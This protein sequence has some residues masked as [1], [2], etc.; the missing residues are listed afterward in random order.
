M[1]NS[2]RVFITASSVLAGGIASPESLFRALC[3]ERRPATPLPDNSELGCLAGMEKQDVAILARHQLLALAAVE[4]AW[5]SAGLSTSR[6]RLRGEGGKIRHPTFACVSGS[7]LGGLCAMESDV[8]QFGA[9]KFPPYAV[10]RWRGNSVA[11]A[12]TLRYGLGGPDFS[13]NAASASGAQ[14]LFLAGSIVASGMA[15][16]VVAVAADSEL[17]PLLRAAMG[18]NGSVSH[19]SEHGPLSA[20]RSGMTP[21][22]GAACLILESEEH[23]TRR[24]T[25]PLAEWIG[26]QSANEA[27]HMMAPDPEARVLEG[28]IGRMQKL[29]HQSRGAGSRV[30]WVSLHATGTPRFDAAE[31]SCLQRVWG[32]NLPLISAM[33]R[34]TGH[35]LAASGLLEAALI[36]EGLR[37]GVLPPW[38]KNLDPALGLPISSPLTT[39]KPEIALQIGQGMGGTVVVNLLGHV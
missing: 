10:S 21:A 3:E 38:P 23:A 37:L 34:T 1:P 19:N 16:L 2:P 6:N 13:I 28:L 11:A 5:S 24:G 27:C 39:Q 17:T 35:A 15:D 31:I 18:R 20:G 14:I 12:A 22:E 25:K 26:G 36:C 33:K 7:S 30:D 9:K 4:M 29:A 8:A 32:G